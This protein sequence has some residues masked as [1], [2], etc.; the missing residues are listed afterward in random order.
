MSEA[1]RH[2]VLVTGIGVE[3]CAG[4]TPDELWDALAAGRPAISALELE[5]PL[6]CQVGGVVKGFDPREHMSAQQVRRTSRFQQL[7]FAA[8][9]KA[10]ADARLRTAPGALYVGTGGGGLDETAHLVTVLRESGWS[11]MNRLGLLRLLPNQAA[12]FVAQ[13]LDI[14]GPVLTLST[15]CASSTDAIAAGM[16]AVRDGTADVVLVGGVESWLD[17]PCLA[18]FCLLD[19]LSRRPAAEA[20]RASRP[21]DRDRDG[22]VPAE[23]AAVLVLESER[24]ALAR[25]ATVHGEVLGAASTCDAHHALAPRPDG[26]VAARTIELACADARLDTAAVDLVSAHGT[27]TPLNDRAETAAI[28]RAFGSHARQVAITAPKSVIGHACGACGV[29]ESV[30]VLLAMR[31]KFV[32]PTANL[33]NPDPDCDLDYTPLVGRPASIDVAV[34]QNFG[35]GG[36][37]SAVVF[38]A[39]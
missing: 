12:G 9:M 7:L 33:E 36:Q 35:F 8:A 27:S 2:R 26:S 18:S 31:E 24:S 1:A 23:G 34:K 21:F 25:G 16:R 19:A 11:K 20:V 38:G 28:K 17:L 6:P 39:A 10:R 37:N 29:L 22:M 13:E 5:Q 15:A 30:G 14:T 3:S 32:P 4:G